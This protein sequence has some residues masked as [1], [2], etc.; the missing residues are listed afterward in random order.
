MIECCKEYIY[1]KKTKSR[2]SKKWFFAFVIILIVLSIYIFYTFV[3]CPRVFEYSKS[4]I[5]SYSSESINKAVTL[6]FEDKLN[7]NDLITVEKDSNGNISLLSTKSLKV[8]YLSRIVENNTKSIL[9]NKLRKGVKIPIM[10]FLGIGLASGYGKEIDFKSLSV[11]SVKCD[12]ES[13]FESVGLNQTL[14]SIYIVVSSSI[15]CFMPFNKNNVTCKSKILISENILIGK[16][17]EIILNSK[18]FS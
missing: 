16:V 5:L 18:L 7:Y 13:N 4:K 17:P 8:N 10:A 6:S 3:T 14:H 2:K 15:D 9:S 11:E 12:F 1:Y